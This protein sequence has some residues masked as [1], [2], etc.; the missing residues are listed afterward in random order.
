MTMVL[1]P[2]NG[3]EHGANV[4]LHTIREL[5]W[6]HAGNKRAGKDVIDGAPIDALGRLQSGRTKQLM[7][8]IT[9]VVGLPVILSQNSDVETGNVNV[10]IGTLK[11]IRHGYRLDYTGRRHAVLCV[12]WHAPSTDEYFC[13]AFRRS[14]WSHLKTE[15]TST[16]DSQ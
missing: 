16:C 1:T 10:C 14:M 12:V 15:K 7:G 8:E 3:N 6:Y 2:Y 13:Q 9:P 5:H 11:K 4:S